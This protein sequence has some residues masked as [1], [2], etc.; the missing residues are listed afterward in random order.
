M[1]MQQ[2]RQQ[3][4][5]IRMDIRTRIAV[6]PAYEPDNLLLLLLNEASQRGLELIVVD[7]GSGDGY[8]KIFEEAKMYAHVISYPEN[9]GKGYAMKTAFRF[10]DRNYRGKY[11]VVV[12]DC[13]GQHKISD[14][15]KL[16]QMAEEQGGTLFLGARRQNAD[17]PLRSK[18]GNGITRNIFRLLTGVNVYDT[19]T[20]LRAFSQG[21]MP[22]MLEIEGDRYE[23]EMNMLLDF[24]NEGIPI[25][26]VPVATIYINKNRGS[27]FNT[28]QDS[29]RIYREILRFSASSLAAFAIDYSLFSA[30]V[31]GFGTEFTIP[32]NLI[33]RVFSA[34]ANFSINRSLVFNDDE[35]LPKSIGKYILLASGILLMNTVILYFLTQVLLLNPYAGKILTELIL[36]FFSFILQK[37]FV[38]KKKPHRKVSDSA[39]LSMEAGRVS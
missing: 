27:H 16:C 35:R 23:Y 29:I 5:V 7:D 28:L 21:L 13:D 39:S 26:E 18:L 14:A 30:L 15:I 12:L 32:A 36:F 25:E 20:G 11:T 9:H 6:I 24:T 31:A 2:R 17:S 3:H 4:E 37:C 22:E 8:K 10:I 38:F 33:A 1:Q 19:Q 34:S